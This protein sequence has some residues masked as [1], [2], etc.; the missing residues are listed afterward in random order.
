LIH[1]FTPECEFV[2]STLFE[3][4][5]C[6]CLT[7]YLGVC[8]FIAFALLVGWQERHPVCKRD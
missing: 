1:I 5:S 4:F 2:D 6:I 3:T 8:A 7:I